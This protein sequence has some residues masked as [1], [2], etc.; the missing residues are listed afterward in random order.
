MAPAPRL[1]ARWRPDSTTAA[2]DE[3]GRFG[4]R[5]S[6]WDWRSDDFAVALRGASLETD[7]VV[8]DGV[9]L[10][11]VGRVD[12]PD[13][14]ARRVGLDPGAVSGDAQ[15]VAAALERR[16]RRALGD[17]LGAYALVSYDRD[18]GTLTVCRDKTGIRSAYYSTDERGAV[19]VST[20][21]ASA[22][23]PT[24]E[25]VAEPDRGRVETFL[26]RGR[27]HGERSFFDGVRRV[28]AGALVRFGTDGPVAE[29]Y[30]TPGRRSRRLDSRRYERRLREAIRA[31]VECRLE[32]GDTGVL[33]SGGIDSTAVACLADRLLAGTGATLPAYTATFPRLGSIDEASGVARVEEHTE[34]VAPARLDLSGIGPDLLPRPEAT[35]SSPC[36]DPS[37][38]PFERLFRAASPE[39]AVLLT[40]FGGNLHDGTTMAH[41]DVL[42]TDGWRAFLGGVRDD[43]RSTARLLATLGPAALL[44][45]RSEPLYRA[46]TGDDGLQGPDG[47]DADDGRYE[48]QTRRLLFDQLTD[49]Y[50]DFARERV[51]RLAREHRLALRHPLLDARVVDLLF[52]APVQCHSPAPRPKHHFRRAVAA[53]V[54]T[55]VRRQPVSRNDYNELVLRFLESTDPATVPGAAELDGRAGLGPD[56]VSAAVDRAVEQR[57]G[58][59]IDEAWRLLAAGSWLQRVRRTAADGKT[60]NQ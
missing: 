16:G 33:M 54:P 57:T 34:R 51:G 39:L 50:V 59:A 47:A 15:L 44:F 27:L 52:A 56:S 31:A 30:W 17:L 21:A 8:R 26:D 45:S 35:P 58:T 7:V 20:A 28:P 55:T 49:G 3:L 46:V 48:T 18:D 4:E 29:R 43:P 2:G 6:Q 25:L 13:R 60:F 5:P 22:A 36:A 23:S 14:T 9:V 19:T 41:L 40:G 11:F 1:F 10:A 53:D 12:A 37:E 24:S 32:D 42:W 38:R